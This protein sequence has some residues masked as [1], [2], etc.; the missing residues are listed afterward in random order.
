MH[1]NPTSLLFPYFFL[2]DGRKVPRLAR[3]TYKNRKIE[4]LERKW[5]RLLPSM[6]R[7]PLLVQVDT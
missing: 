4:W 5:L 6:A 2:P 7:E 3:E 1:W